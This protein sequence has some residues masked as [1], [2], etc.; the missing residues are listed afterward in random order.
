MIY[1]IDIPENAEVTIGIHVE[2]AAGSWGSFDDV[3][4]NPAD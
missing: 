3:L 1:D 2:A 4:L